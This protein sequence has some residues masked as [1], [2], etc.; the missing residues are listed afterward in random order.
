MYQV[1]YSMQAMIPVPKESASSVCAF[2]KDVVTNPSEDSFCVRRNK[3][4]FS[5]AQ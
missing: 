5:L 4:L 2:N 1:I 3:N